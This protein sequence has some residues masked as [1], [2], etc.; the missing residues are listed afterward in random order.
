[1]TMV[2]TW[3]ADVGPSRT[4]TV[5][6]RGN[7]G[8]V[9]PEVVL[10]L[11]ADLAWRAAEA[12]W[13]TGAAEIGFA[14]PDDFAD[15][16][17]VVMGVFGGYAYFN[18]SLMRLLGVRT[19]GMGPDLIDEQFLGEADVPGYEPRPGD[20]RLRATLRMV[21]TALKTLRAD[22]VPLLDEMRRQ[23]DRYRAGFPGLDADDDALFGYV[24]TSFTEATEF[25]ISSHVIN[26]MRATIAAGA[27]ADF[28]QK[29]L[30]NP[31]L[32]LELTTGI[33]DVVSAQPAVELW[34]IANETPAPEHDAAFAAF[35]D[36]HGHRG[37]NE[38]SIH[39]R[40]WAAFP[41]L[42]LAAIDTMRGLDPERSPEV[43]GRRM[44]ERRLEAVEA[45]KARLGRRGRKLESLIATVTLWSRAREESKDLVVKASQLGRHAYLELVRR[46]AERGGVADRTGPLLLTVAEFETYLADPPSMVSTIGD[47]R[48]HYE[49]LSALEPPFAFDS[50]AHEHG[51]PPIDTWS[52]RRT[53]DTE[54]V[55]SAVT[56]TE[57]SGAAGAPGTAT[58]RAR[59]V[60]DPGEP[61][62]M[63]PGDVLIAPVTDPAWTPLFVG[64]AAVVVEIGA[65][66]SHSMIVSRELGIPCV[67]GV[68]DATL[69]IPDGAL[70]EVDGSSGTVRLL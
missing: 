30:G 20:R 16:P 9:Y 51:Y 65:A 29:H 2:N 70:V 61:G 45:A 66:M 43:Q 24:R 64:A 8:E 17:F 19:P 27:L 59:V 13:R 31:D 62:D 42:A 40:D 60:L 5:Y 48:A 21:A 32:A 63:A 23:V 56:G 22:E 18:V 36:A 11:E 53:A 6:T 12:G 35:L 3:P 58:G 49:Q 46:A 28:C 39:G 44:A 37:P 38:F 26:T 54:G 25:F 67:V 50:A 47:R 1:M 7:V 57:L 69:R 14:V 41:E 52:P 55:E 15:E 4:W 34:R 68:D 33:G 10:P